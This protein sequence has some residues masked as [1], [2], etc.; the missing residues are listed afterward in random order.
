MG[1]VGPFRLEMFPGF[2]MKI[3]RETLKLVF[4]LPDDIVFSTPCSGGFPNV[5]ESLL[6]YGVVEGEPVHPEVETVCGHEC[7]RNT[8][9][10]YT[11]RS[12][13]F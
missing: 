3:T 7:R 6:K 9:K 10:E 4:G 11:E 1:E 8:K 13:R 2:V 12:R 5:V